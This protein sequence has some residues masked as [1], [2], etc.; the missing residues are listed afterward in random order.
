VTAAES[1]QINVGIGFTGRVYRT[2]L[3]YHSPSSAPASVIVKLH[4]AN[5]QIRA[6]LG[7]IGV[8]REIPFYRYL[9]ADVGMRTPRMHCGE[10][11]P[12][13]YGYVLVLEDLAPAP[14][15]DSATPTPPDQA[16]ALVR[17]LAAL[18]AEW[19][20]SPRLAE[21]RWLPSLEESAEFAQQNSAL[22]WERASTAGNV[23]FDPDAIAA[24]EAMIEHWPAIA[25]YLSSPPFTL[26][27]GDFRLDNLGFPNGQ[28]GEVIAFD[29]QVAGRARGARD[30]AYLMPTVD[31]SADR[32]VIPQRIL[33]SYHDAL[34][35]H[36][37]TDYT[38]QQLT[39]DRRVATFYYVMIASG[40]IGMLDFSSPRGQQLARMFAAQVDTLARELDLVALAKSD[41]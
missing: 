3:T 31:M 33:A 37:V 8:G 39:Y 29:W 13:N 11:N 18:H 1:E 26:V 2:T 30:L 15:G 24:I 19:W 20:N 28:L 12:E 17:Q 40:A 6:L 9:A 36:G 16:E 25:A 5:D 38:L 7:E 41:F 32:A 14:I 35:A 23:V 27:H 21:F 10:Y 34:V 22:A 4:S